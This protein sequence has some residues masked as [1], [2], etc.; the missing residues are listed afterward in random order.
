[1]ADKE[2]KYNTIKIVG[3]Y[4]AAKSI[5]CMIAW[6]SGYFAERDMS[7]AFTTLVYMQRKPAPPLSRMLQ[8]TVLTYTFMSIALTALM[9]VAMY[10]TDRPSSTDKVAEK[11]MCGSW[12]LFDMGI[13]LLTIFVVGNIICKSIENQ[14]YF[15]Y[16]TEGLRAIRAS[17]Q[18]LVGLLI[19]VTTF[20]F[21][22]IFTTKRTF[23]AYNT[24]W[25][26]KVAS[27][28]RERMTSKP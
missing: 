24:I 14:V 21:A 26:S 4:L 19:A 13:S 6:I 7:E 25:T 20:P 16:R 9:M 23:E 10:V 1:M 12:I 8:T 27:S 17:R 2:F 22:V 11:F 5:A 15:N 18:M 3:V 28:I